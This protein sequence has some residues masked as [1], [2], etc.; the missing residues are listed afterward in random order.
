MNLITVFILLIALLITALVFSRQTTKPDF[1]ESDTPIGDEL[2][3][4]MGFKKWDI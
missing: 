1:N 2:A 3:Y 4:E